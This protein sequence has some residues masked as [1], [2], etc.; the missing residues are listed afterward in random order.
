MFTPDLL[1]WKAYEKCTVEIPP[2]FYACIL[3]MEHLG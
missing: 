2:F 3:I 1:E